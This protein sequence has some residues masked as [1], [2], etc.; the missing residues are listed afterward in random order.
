[1]NHLDENDILVDIQHA[2]RLKRSC[3]TQLI[4][5]IHNFTL[6]LNSKIQ[7][8]VAVLDFSKAFDKVDHKL[9]LTKLDYYGI[10]GLQLKWLESFLTGRS[11]QVVIDGHKSTSIDVTSGV[12][13]GTVLGP[14]LFII[15]INDIASKIKSQVRLFA[16]D[17][18]LYRPIYGTSDCHVFQ[19]DLDILQ[20]WAD[21]WKMNFNVKKCFTMNLTLATKNIIQFE[22]KM[23]GEILEN[24][25]ATMYLGI[26]ITTNLKWNRHINLLTTKANRVLNFLKRNLKNCPKSIKERAYLTYARPLTE[27]ASTVWDPHTKANIDKVE[28]VQRRAARFVANNYERKASV[29]EMIQTLGWPTLQQRRQYFNLTLFYRIIHFHVAIPRTCLPP[30][31]SDSTTH[32][33]RHHHSLAFQ[34]PQCRIDTFKHSFF[35]RTVLLWNAL[36]EEIARSTPLEKYKELLAGIYLTNSSQ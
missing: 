29:T 36:P 2:F 27:Y 11:Q 17:C 20:T 18:I 35:P 25:E 23:K 31:I 22:Y 9:L 7:T 13:Q 15:F 28:K 32:R 21:T 24:V 34:I 26:T 33:S 16:D 1:M 19:A 3:E 10:R 14:I 5:T 30:L 4:Q 6:N 12:P 8:A